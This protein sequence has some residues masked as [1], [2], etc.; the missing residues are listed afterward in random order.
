LS[1]LEN[2]VLI[3]GLVGRAAI[4]ET[5]GFYMPGICAVNT[6]VGSDPR[7]PFGGV[8]LSGY[9]RECAA[10]G[11]REFMNVKTVTIK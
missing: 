1:S 6:M 3:R 4:Q 9:G 11:I 5:L 8:K 2:K 10:D 7:L